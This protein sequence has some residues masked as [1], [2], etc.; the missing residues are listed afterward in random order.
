M[1]AAGAVDAQTASTNSL[2]N[3]QNAFS[4]ATTGIN[5]VLPM[6][7]DK[8]VTYVPAGAR[9]KVKAKG[10]REKGKGKGQEAGRKPNI[11]PG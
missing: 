3:A 7:P 11:R 9:G 10:K 4:T 5:D 1:E 6:S 2:E 8:S